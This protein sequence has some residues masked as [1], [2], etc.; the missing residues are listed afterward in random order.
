MY[1]QGTIFGAMFGFIISMWLSIGA[2]FTNIVTPPMP[3][4]I[5]GCNMSGEESIYYFFK[6]Q[7][8]V[9]KF[10]EDIM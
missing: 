1:L 6:D 5:D 7:C 2:S 8:F 4:P 3:T 10:Y 9:L